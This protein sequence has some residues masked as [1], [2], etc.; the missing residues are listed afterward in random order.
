M[1]AREKVPYNGESAL[2]P[3]TKRIYVSAKCIMC[4]LVLLREGRETALIL[5]GI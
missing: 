1:T 4:R 5:F 3:L 2:R